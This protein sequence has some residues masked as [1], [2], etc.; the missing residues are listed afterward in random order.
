MR[1]VKILAGLLIALALSSNVQAGRKH[2]GD[3][4]CT[5]GDCQKTD[6]GHADS[7]ALIEMHKR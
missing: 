7:S 4:Y 6:S 3:W 1:T 5:N 2:Y